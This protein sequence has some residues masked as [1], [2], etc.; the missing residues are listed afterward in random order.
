M[1]SILLCCLLASIKCFGA[2]PIEDKI[3]FICSQI[4]T[5]PNFKYEDY[6]SKTFINKVKFE[7]LISIFSNIYNDSGSC[8]EATL[9]TPSKF[10]LKTQLADQRFIITLDEK[11]LI[12]GLQ[13]LGRSEPSVKISDKQSIFNEFNKLG[14]ISSLIIKDFSKSSPLLE[15]NSNARIAL[16]SEFKLYI[17]HYLNQQILNSKLNWSDK[18]K[19]QEEIKSLPS[20][21]LQ[22]YPD[23]TELTLYQIASLMIAIS[24]NT[25]TDHLINFLIKESI[26]SSMIGFNSY[27][28]E[29]TPLLSTMDLFRIRTLDSTL[30]NKYM[31]LPAEQ[32]RI[33]LESLK[34]ELSRND[35]ATK[36]ANWDQPKDIQKVEWFA[37]VNDICSVVQDI[38]TQAVSNSAILDILSNNVPFVWIEDNPSFEYIGYKGGSEPGVLTMTFLVKTKSHKWG[39]ISMGINNDKQSLN[40]NQ[41]ADLFHAILNYAGRLLNN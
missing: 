24:D 22:N 35:I 2:T 34:H 3:N 14:G 25:A 39:C 17:L 19:I 11:N 12:N 36:L 26:E 41:I 23:G 37:N 4:S 15:I 29:N 33:Y 9:I 10:I 28:D 27:V 13:Y 18:L 16:G 1:K 40:E 31:N 20:G 5:K 6:F 7:D 32:K 8:T 21:I 30:V 38:Q